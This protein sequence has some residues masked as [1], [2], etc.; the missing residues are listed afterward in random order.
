MS[1]SRVFNRRS[2]FVAVIAVL[3]MVASSGC[4]KKTRSDEESVPNAANADVTSGDSD[5]GNAM[6]LETIHFPYDAFALGAEAK[7]IL[8]ENASIL[9]ANEN[10]KIQVEG[11]CDQRG[12]IQYNIA[13]GE[14]RANVAKRYLVDHGV[15][16]S[17][18]TTISFGKEKP[19]DPSD[20]EAAYA[21]NRRDNFAITSK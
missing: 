21:K 7:K 14:K 5:S 15:A 4:A 9:K 19:V 2:V 11:H 20:T 13:L 10:V 1:A 18:I 3:A 6:G 8:N 17:R 16:A 12:G